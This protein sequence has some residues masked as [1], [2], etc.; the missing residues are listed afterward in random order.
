MHR[1]RTA[2]LLIL[3]FSL[4]ACNAFKVKTDYDQTA[5]F[6][7]FKTFA[8]AGPAEMN[9]GGI[10]DNSL[11]QKRIESAV[12]RQ[13]VA[14]GLRQ[15][16]ID[17]PQDLRVHYWVGVQDKQRLESSG[18]TVGVARGPGGGYGWGA[19]YGGGVTTYEYREGTLILDLIEPANKQLVWRATIIGTLQDSTKDNVELGNEAIAK[20]F[21]NYPPS[22]KAQ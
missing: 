18:P 15:V 13:L 2:C 11:M 20:A 7:S 12:V 10:Y 5:D 6:S 22:A 21:E 19:G 4:S 14:K 17:E 16:S 3:T 9:K 8:F 1:G